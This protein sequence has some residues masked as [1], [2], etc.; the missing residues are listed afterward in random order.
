MTQQHSF[1]HPNFGTITVDTMFCMCLISLE[2]LTLK[3]LWFGQTVYNFKFLMSNYTVEKI[4]FGIS[5]WS[6]PVLFVNFKSQ[7]RKHQFLILVV[8]AGICALAR[9]CVRV[10]LSEMHD[11]YVFSIGMCSLQHM[12][13]GQSTTFGSWFSLSSMDFR[14]QT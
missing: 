6:F 5:L 13:G 11:A 8:V 9:V 4:K 2:I 1:V 7:N 3:W 10:C 14:D 12:V